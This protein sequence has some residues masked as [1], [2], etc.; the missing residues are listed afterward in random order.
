MNAR[1][2]QFF[3]FVRR[4]PY[5]TGCTILTIALAVTAWFLWDQN[6]TLELV[7]QQRA[8]DGE[9][10]L[11]L[12][13]SGSTQRQELAT[14]R[15]VTRRIEDNLLIETNLAENSWYFFKLEQQ[16]KARLPQVSQISSPINDHSTLYK[17][18]PYTL[19]VE[20]N[21]D[22]VGAFLLG[23]ETGPRLVAITGFSFTRRQADGSN[24]ALDLNVELLGKK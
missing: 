13:V 11:A 24:L 20:G 6:Q 18:I 3:G 17:R 22:Q 9:A 10:M 16:T 5:P 7:R 15:E 19:R 2:A 8:K 1:L 14:A 21:Y 12:L 23:L 4:Y